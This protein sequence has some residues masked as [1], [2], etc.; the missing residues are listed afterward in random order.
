[1]ANS[2]HGRYLEAEVMGASPVRL[3]EMLYRAALEAVGAARRH[4]RDGN[5]RE[6]SRSITKAWGIINELMLSL[7]HTQGGQISRGLV[8]LYAYMQ[9]RL[10]EANGQQIDAPLEDVEKLLTVLAEAW[11]LI[12]PAAVAS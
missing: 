11:R 7:D 4:L 8:E 6:R 1:M 5:I 9:G 3:V 10:L 2:I 12:P